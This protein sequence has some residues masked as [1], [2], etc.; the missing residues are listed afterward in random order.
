MC[1]IVGR[2]GRMMGWRFISLVVGSR[3]IRG[4]KRGM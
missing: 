2:L 4:V 1:L 3:R